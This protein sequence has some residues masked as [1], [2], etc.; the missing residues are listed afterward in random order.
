MCKLLA[1]AFHA[2][3]IPIQ[4]ANDGSSDREG[5]G[6]S[7]G[8]T[9]RGPWDRLH[10]G[11]R[12]RN[13]LLHGAQRARAALRQ[14]AFRDHRGDGRD[15]DGLWRD[16]ALDASGPHAAGAGQ[17]AVR[18][19]RARAGPPGYPGQR[20]DRRRLRRLGRVPR[21][22]AR[23]GPQGAGDRRPLA[24]HQR[25]LRRAA[26]AP[27]RRQPHRRDD[28]R[29]RHHRDPDEHVLLQPGE[30]VR[31]PPRDGP[32]RRPAQQERRSGCTVARVHALGR[33]AGCAGRARGELARGHRA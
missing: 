10:A 2:F 31:H 15:G 13:G 6:C 28:R 18:A 17:G 4:E 19:R 9:G 8:D 27:Q 5:G 12:G 16:R 21:A 29:H 24:H 3:L 20:P 11:R 25:L 14:A 1:C 23:Q 22:L 26:D 32:G 30:V 33:G 7:R